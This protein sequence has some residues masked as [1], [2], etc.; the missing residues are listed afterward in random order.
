[1]DSVIYRKS[2]GEHL[3]DGFNIALLLLLSAVTLYPL[4]YVLFASVSNPVA[5]ARG[6][7]LF[8]SLKGMNFAAYK[9]VFSNAMIAYGYRN[10]LLY[11]TLG[12]TLNVLMTAFG[13]Y[14]LSRKGL[15]GQKILMLA[16]VFTM[17]FTGGMIPSF[18]LVYN[19]GIYD[20]IWAVI[21]PN[22]IATMNL[23]IMR[24][25]FAS[26]PVELEES[27]RLDGAGD[28][29]ILFRI[30]MPI[31]RALVAVIIMFYAVGHWNDFMTGLIYLRNRLLYP[32][33][34]VL[35]EILIQENLQE[36][37]G[38]ITQDR[39]IISANIKYA[40][41]VVA[42]LPILC[43]YPFVQKYFVKGVMIGSIKQ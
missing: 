17:Q 22:A 29:T 6:G 26:V 8:W 7:P 35:R 19:I 43:V 20:T 38:G 4:L 28:F 32:L 40:T 37:M 13:G 3:F 30:F 18:L 27:A 11:M 2:T 34:L 31:S 21:L 23:I 5:M 1:M 42:T 39:E 33:Q 16:I 36:S 10:T 12:T 41:I 14:A 25:S 24:T 9:A 15:P